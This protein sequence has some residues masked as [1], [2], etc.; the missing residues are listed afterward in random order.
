M[1]AY[2]Y[3]S[4]NG[5]LKWYANFYYVDWLGERKHKCKRGF[6]TKKEALEWERD[7]LDR[8]S[9][10]PTILFSSL[11]ENYLT[12][13]EP[14]LKPTT[15]KGKRH[16]IESK[17]LPF[18]G[19]MQI[20]DI[21]PVTI[22]RWQNMLMDYTQ[23]NGEPYAQTYLKTI[24]NQL[25]AI[26][27]YAV[28]Y[29]NLQRNP[30]QATGSIGKSQADEMSIWTKAQYE[31]FIKFEKKQAFRTAFDILFH[32]G[33]REG[34]LLA[35]TP[36]DI[37]DDPPALAINKNYAVV[38]REEYFLTPKTKKGDRIV[39]NP[40][41]LYDEVKAFADSMY[42]EKDEKPFYF[43]KSGLTAEFKR[44]TQQ[45]GLPEIRVHDLRHSHVSLS[46]GYFWDS[47]SDCLR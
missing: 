28:K 1:P 5:K 16:P 27:N 43:R 39:T 9:K 7:F 18:F 6:S 44:A 23:E 41:S 11:V 22:H 12:E 47:L 20:C 40:Q 10:D 45:A 17:L 35:L 14:R 3:Y 29:Y 13:M 31:H 38:E 30:C 2:K 34:E 15:M 4:K 32:S 33:I 26:L 46:Q 37:L 21:D 42:I 24:N 8:G 19:R 36:E 25:S